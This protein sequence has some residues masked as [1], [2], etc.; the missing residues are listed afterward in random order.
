MHWVHLVN[1]TQKVCL[2][3]TTKNIE[4]QCWIAKTVWQRIPGRRARNSKTPTTKTTINYSWL[5]DRRCWRPA[6]TAVGVQL[7]IRYREA[8]ISTLTTNTTDY[9]KQLP[10]EHKKME[11][12]HQHQQLPHLL[13][14]QNS[15]H[16]WLETGCLILAQWGWTSL[17][18]TKHP[19][20]S[21]NIIIIASFAS[22]GF[23]VSA[24]AVCNSL[25]SGIRDSSSTHTFRRLLKTHWFQQAFGSP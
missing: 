12:V 15:D 25:P 1:I 16:I 10:A 17:S 4:T 8:F 5:A 3:L 18:S 14:H 22:R 6:T 23:S 13:H 21:F 11:S 7:F 19:T 2:Q 24:P 20:I 9:S